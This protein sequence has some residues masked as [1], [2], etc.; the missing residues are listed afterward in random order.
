MRVILQKLLVV[1]RFDDERV[2]LA[3]TLDQH[4]RGAAE[5]GDVT[6]T[7]RSGM[8]READGIDRVMRHGES[9]DSDIA[10]GKFRTGAKETPVAMTGQRARANR[11]RGE[12]VAIDRDFEFAAEHFKAADMV[13][14]F[15]RKEDA[16]ELLGS[17]TA[18]R[19]AHDELARA[20]SSIDQNATMIG[21]DE[22]AVPGAAA[23]E[24]GQ[25]EHIRLVTDALSV[26]K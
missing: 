14:M 18:E 26:H 4:L 13:A 23:A 8:K 5:I 24:H 20:Q 17:N 19:E 12:R 10:D 16:I 15:V 11:F 2:H 22:R 1:I 25:T 7:A 9:L 21:G 6:E 3:Q